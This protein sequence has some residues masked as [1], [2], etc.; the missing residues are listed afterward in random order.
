M[1]E[2]YLCMHKSELISGQTN[3]FL[4]M[5]VRTHIFNIEACRMNSQLQIWNALMIMHKYISYE[6]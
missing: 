1:C 2:V 6:T 3:S 5:H 4:C